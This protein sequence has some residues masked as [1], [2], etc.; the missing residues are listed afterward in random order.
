MLPAGC[1]EMVV[2]LYRMA[3]D[4]DTT[5]I[6]SPDGGESMR[7]NTPRLPNNF[8]D[9][10]EAEFTPDY[11]TGR[12]SSSTRGGVAI[13]RDA[14]GQVQVLKNTTP[15][16]TVK[17]GRASSIEIDKPHWTPRIDANIPPWETIW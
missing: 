17:Q 5:A 12:S 2:D 11:K 8:E 6:L 14:G 1:D 9:G 16:Y 15:E 3:R 7:S 4:S 13:E 10:W